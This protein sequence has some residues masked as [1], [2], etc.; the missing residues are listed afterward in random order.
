MII[1]LGILE[2][3]ADQRQRFLEGKV[4]QVEATLAEPGC[5]DY[6]FS[7]DSGDPARVRL[8]ERWASLADLEAHV[9]GL[10]S[11]PAPE[12]PPVSSRMVEVDVFDAEP[13]RPPWA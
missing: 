12:S 13:V 9:V 8:V 11:A 2:V 6:C 10:R 4:P 5:V 1:V 7:A 3:D